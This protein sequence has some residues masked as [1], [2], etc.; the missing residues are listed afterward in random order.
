MQVR[1]GGRD[2]PHV[3]LPGFRRAHPLE[4]A[5]LEHPQQL[6]LQVEREIGDLVQ[7]QR[8]PIGQLEAA[9]AIGL[10][11]GERAFDV[12]EQLALEYPS[13][14]PPMFTVTMG[15]AARS[16]TACSVRATTSLPVPG[17]PVIST[18]ASDGPT[19]A[20]SCSTG[21]IAGASAIMGPAIGL[22]EPVLGFQ[23]PRRDARPR[24][25]PT[26]C[27]TMASRRALSQGFWTKSLAPRRMASTAISTLPHAVMTTTG[28]IES[29]CCTFEKQLE[30]LLPGRR[31]AGVVE[32][33]Q[34][35]VILLL[36]QR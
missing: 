36:I 7:E 21:C 28:S 12:A 5:G 20:M 29:T 17:S 30:P 13:E 11:V 25:A 19:R 14:R 34:Q 9:D 32:V 6:G 1:V 3:D 18:L 2:D 24:K 15:C 22:Q 31:V 8:A 35:K 23:P 16:L 27:V 4:L 33:H 10:G 26:A